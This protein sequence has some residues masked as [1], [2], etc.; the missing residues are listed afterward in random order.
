MP[1]FFQD[2]AVLDQDLFVWSSRPVLSEWM[3]F[4]MLLPL[5][6]EYSIIPTPKSDHYPAENL[7]SAKMMS[8]ATY[9]LIKIA[10][11]MKL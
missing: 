4:F 1:A 3:F 8:T 7:R 2:P 10:K 6:V 11:P 9:Y 5:S